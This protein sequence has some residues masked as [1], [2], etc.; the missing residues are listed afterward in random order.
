MIS[1]V[2]IPIS[3]VSLQV[4]SEPERHAT[5]YVDK[6]S[7]QPTTLVVKLRDTCNSEKHFDIQ[8]QKMKAFHALQYIQPNITVQFSWTLR[9]PMHQF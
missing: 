2:H 8:V 3:A 5:W 9:S 1:Y 6:Q 4:R 7:V